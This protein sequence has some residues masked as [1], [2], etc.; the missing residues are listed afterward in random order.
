MSKGDHDCGQWKPDVG[1]TAVVVTNGHLADIYGKTAHGLIRGSER[2]TVLA[3][4]DPQYAGRDAGEV[5][6]DIPR[7]IPVFACL[8]AMF[9]AGETRPDYCIIGCATHGGVIPRALRSTRPKRSNP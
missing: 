1:G 2:F 8:K 4:I 6:D 3:V 5:L 9:A 7:N